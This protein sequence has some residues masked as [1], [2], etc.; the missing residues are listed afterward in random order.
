[1]RP[2]IGVVCIPAIVIAAICPR[3]SGWSGMN[4]LLHISTALTQLGEARGRSNAPPS[5]DSEEYLLVQ[6]ARRVRLCGCLVMTLQF[7]DGAHILEAD[8]EVCLPACMAT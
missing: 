5:V 8:C 6:N 1:M 7:C 4:V 2:P 3:V